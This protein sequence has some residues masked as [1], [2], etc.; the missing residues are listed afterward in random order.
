MKKNGMTLP[1]LL[2]IIAIVI[3]AVIA[4]FPISKHIKANKVKEEFLQKIETVYK[5]AKKDFVAANEKAGGELVY[6]D[7]ED[8]TRLLSS[9]NGGINYYIAF[10][11][12]GEIVYFVLSDS[13]YKV[14]AGSINSEKEIFS[15]DFGFEGSGKKYIITLP[16][17][18]TATKTNIVY[19]G[20]EI[21]LNKNNSVNGYLLGDVNRDKKLTEQD[22]QLISSYMG[23]KDLF[24]EEQIKLADVDKN[25]IVD[26]NDSLQIS[27]YISAQTSVYDTYN[28]NDEKRD[29]NN[30]VLNKYNSY[31]GYLIGDINRDGKLTDADSD[32]IKDYYNGK[33]WNGKI[34][35]Y[36]NE[37]K[38]KFDS[39]LA[40][41][42]SLEKRIG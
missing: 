34:K 40:E 26:N 10:N 36:F 3:I 5:T 23:S 8:E 16:S 11:S 2:I 30:I 42:T 21:K 38:L 1:Q 33:E 20:M 9:N 35:Q 27:R 15:S 4:Y 41:E 29:G 13:D 12:A 7:S 14:E 32:V 24:D 22:A 18:Y 37:Y 31:G 17:V 6:L 25:G 19:D 39:L 28:T